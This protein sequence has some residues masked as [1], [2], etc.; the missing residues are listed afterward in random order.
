MVSYVPHEGG[1]DG[2]DLPV[3]MYMLCVAMPMIILWVCGSMA[4][5][6]W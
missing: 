4:V 5:M 1:T 3:C 6:L 2:E